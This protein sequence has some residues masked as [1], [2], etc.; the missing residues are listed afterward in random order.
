M[1]D[2]AH[3]TITSSLQKEN[4]QMRQRKNSPKADER[5]KRYELNIGGRILTNR[6]SR[7]DNKMIHEIV[8]QTVDPAK[9]DAARSHPCAYRPNIVG[10]AWLLF[11]CRL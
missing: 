9:R 2:L 6:V 11:N 7:E 3:R 4:C 1:V 5:A 8:I 10:A